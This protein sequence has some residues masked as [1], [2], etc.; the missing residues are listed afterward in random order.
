MLN[1]TCP[2]W[3]LK[4]A[5]LSAALLGEGRIEAVWYLGNDAFTN[6]FIKNKPTK[7]SNYT[8][9]VIISYKMTITSKIIC[10]KHSNSK[11]K[12]LINLAPEVIPTIT[13]TTNTC[14]VFD[15][16]FATAAWRP[17]A[18]CCLA[19]NQELVS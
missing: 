14:Q 10:L 18:L 16:L 1:L 13:Q 3:Q 11:R 17:A 12:K 7:L 6:R 9:L 2:V 8:L 4:F 5:G 19:H 15:F